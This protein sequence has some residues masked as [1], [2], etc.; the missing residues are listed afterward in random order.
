M[1]RLAGPTALLCALVCCGPARAQE[2]AAL[3]GRLEPDRTAEH[4]LPAHDGVMWHLWLEAAEEVDLDLRVSAG[5]R[6]WASSL[7][8]ADEALLV[9]ALEG[10]T[11]RVTHYGGPATDY[12]L[13]ATPVLPG[14][15]LR[16]GRTV[17]G[18]LGEEEAFAFHEL[19]PLPSGRFYLAHLEGELEEADL[20]LFIYDE[21]WRPLATSAEE[22]G[23]EAL[24]IT[25]A[26]ERR[27]LVI[28]SFHDGAAPYT[29]KLEELRVDR[30]LSTGTRVRGQVAPDGA[31]YLRLRALQEGVVTIRLEGPADV[32]FDLSVF[33][34][35][36]YVRQSLEEA[37]QEQLI[38]N[39]RRGADLLIVVE[40]ADGSGG[41]FTLATERLDQSALAA[42]G[43]GGPRT[44]AV[45]V[46]LASYL[47]VTELT[48]TSGD[49]LLLYQELLRDGTV[50]ARRSLVLVDERATRAG[51]VA[52]L[53]TIAARAD[54]DDLF[55]FFYSGHGGCDA[56]DASR[57]DPQDE[58]DGMDEYLVCYDSTG[59]SLQGDLT[60]DDLKALLD[61]I[62][63]RRQVVLLDACYSGGM[64][65]L[66]DREGRFGLF[67]SLETQ[68]SSEAP[69]LRAGLLT[70]LLARGLTG[71]ADGD[72]DRAVTL[73]E[74]AA[75]VMR[76][77]PNT[78]PTCQGALEEKLA[79]APAPDDE[80]EW[81]RDCGEELSGENARQIP[82]VVD[83]T[84][85]PAFVITRPAPRRERR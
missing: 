81:C 78:C 56:P 77:V 38:V 61:R 43:A 5:G 19:P 50:E 29:L 13:H 85:D 25:P 3:E 70:G 67:S 72:G 7:P 23:D 39:L 71:E 37:A 8:G 16:P 47:E 27:Y 9:P 52:A 32:D 54:E 11:A 22:A 75:F 26:R 84:G 49:A 65:E 40:S 73:S 35:D 1:R 57:G 6:H 33:G 4:R 62:P 10:L 2:A 24:V 34:S 28:R 80:A 45:F 79:G 17:E 76:V 66:I 69:E 30:S 83:R 15:P 18:G 41:P 58:A 55:L 64:A 51:L 59:A 53:E 20:D 60:D 82:V 21:R 14:A 68:V 42:D 31:V 36:P 46:G 48:Y 44:W 12:T 74:L 63:A